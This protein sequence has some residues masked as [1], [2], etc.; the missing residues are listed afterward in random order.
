MM[1]EF[2]VRR[3]FRPRDGFEP[4]LGP[5]LAW[6]FAVNR[7]EEAERSGVPIERLR[8]G[9]RERVERVMGPGAEP[10]RR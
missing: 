6:A 3:R 4:W 1:D 2:E 10:P 9:E 5:W 7:A 8:P